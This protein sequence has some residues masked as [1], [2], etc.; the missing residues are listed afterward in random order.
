MSESTSS[1][2][3]TSFSLAY[4]AVSSPSSELAMLSVYSSSS[5]SLAGSVDEKEYL[6]RALH[7][8]KIRVQSAVNVYDN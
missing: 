3:V 5:A 7:A 1:S 2:A 8:E 4:D 6:V